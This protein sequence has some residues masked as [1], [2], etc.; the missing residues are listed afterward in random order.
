VGEGAAGDG[1]E[2][3]GMG[4]GEA[5][6]KPSTLFVISSTLFRLLTPSVY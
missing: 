6:G 5:A 4:D 1:G 2:G 3:K